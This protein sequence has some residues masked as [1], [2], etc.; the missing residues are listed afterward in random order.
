MRLIF[1]PFVSS[2]IF[3]M[4]RKSYVEHELYIVI[5]IGRVTLKEFMQDNVKLVFSISHNCVS[6]LTEFCFM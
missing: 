4:N 2:S 3:F 1:V 6:P 5:L